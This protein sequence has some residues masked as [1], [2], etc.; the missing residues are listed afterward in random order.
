[1]FYTNVKGVI[2]WKG[3]K[4]IQNSLDEVF[5]SNEVLEIGWVLVNN[6]WQAPERTT[7]EKILDLESSITER[8]KQEA[9]LGD[10]YALAKIKKVQE[11]IAPLRNR[12]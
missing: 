11:L 1:M 7:L 12:L 4:K 3:E 2:G 6:E 10:E 8:H 5:K 9:I